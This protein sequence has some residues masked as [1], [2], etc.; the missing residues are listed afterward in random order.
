M[1]S[2]IRIDRGAAPLRAAVEAWENHG[3]GANAEGDELSRTSELAEFLQ[4]PLMDFRRAVG[5]KVLGEEL[6][7]EGLLARV[8][9]GCS[10]SSDFPRSTVLGGYR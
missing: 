1:S 5:K 2:G 7:S 4:R 8:G 9:R 3:V 6:A 10:S